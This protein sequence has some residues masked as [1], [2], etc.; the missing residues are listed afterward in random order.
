MKSICTFFFSLLKAEISW[1]YSNC[2]FTEIKKNYRVL[3]RQT[4]T[5]AFK[6]KKKKGL[7]LKLFFVRNVREGNIKAGDAVFKQ[8]QN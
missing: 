8:P 6:K 4:L 5:C 2:D 3:N 7:I 1:N